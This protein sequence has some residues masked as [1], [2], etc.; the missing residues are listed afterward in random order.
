MT[1]Q[2]EYETALIK[3]CYTI[4][5][6]FLNAFTLCQNPSLRAI[7]ACGELWKSIR[8]YDQSC[9]GFQIT[10]EAMGESSTSDVEIEDV[11]DESLSAW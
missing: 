7:F 3:L 8:E 6:W 11:S 9:Q 2:S 4:L 10:V 1:L 5:S